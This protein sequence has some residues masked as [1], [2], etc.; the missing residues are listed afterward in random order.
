MS[1]LKTKSDLV[2]LCDA[3]LSEIPGTVLK[4]GYDRSALTPGIVH[5]GLGNFHRAHQA[6]YL[7]RLMQEGKA[8]DWAIIG[9]GVRPYDTVMREK[10][11]NQDWLTTLISLEPAGARAEVIGPMIDYVQI[12]EGNAR[13]IQVMANPLIRIVSLTITEGGYYIDPMSGELDK[14]HPD[15]IHDITHPHEPRS[16][17]GA[18]VAAL[19]SRMEKGIGPFTVQSCDNLSGNGDV[20]KKTVISLARETDPQCA[21]WIEENGAFPNS[22]VDCIV[23]ATGPSEIALAQQFGVYDQAPVTHEPFRQWVIEDN[24]AIGRPDW[25]LAGA[26]ITDDV[27]GY[28]AMKIRILNAGHQV[29]ANIG[30]LL[31]LETISD[32]MEHAEIGA[33]FQ[34][35]EVE[36]ILPHVAPVPNMMPRDY[37]ALI[38]ERFRNPAIKDTT[39]RV[40]FDGSSRHTGFVLPIVREALAKQK[41]VEGLALVEALWA[42]MCTGYRED[43]TQIAPNDPQWEDLIKA[44]RE[45]QH[46]P[47]AWLEQHHF[48]DELANQDVFAR[49]FCD[50]LS[51]IY[52]HGSLA[53]VQSYIRGT[54]P[55][56]R[57]IKII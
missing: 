49:S 26:V 47:M 33:F 29:L 3:Q 4:P 7:H 57:A 17:F 16:V 31:S 40:A 44:A 32:C 9:A 21:D 54:H 22:M 52:S 27:H 51:A 15:I 42:R 35:V 5:I 8:L 30:E 36:E 19:K 45:A 24:F 37:L 50:W 12:E 20:A 25:G 2:Q 53:T 41:P 10:L 43:G 13:L 34:K 14:N 38:T 6:W 1:D 48:Y 46:R 55:R 39:R 18:I 56:H 11:I 28:E 23:P